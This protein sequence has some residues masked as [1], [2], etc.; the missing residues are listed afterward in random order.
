M[1]A[2]DD[3]AQ[4][5]HLRA[6]LQERCAEADGRAV[7]E[8]LT[9]GHA[10]VLRIE[11]E[12]ARNLRAVEAALHRGALDDVEAL[13]RRRRALLRARGGLR[14]DLA[15]LGA[16]RRANERVRP[17]AGAAG[18]PRDRARRAS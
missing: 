18:R 7:V 9:T 17:D 15:V 5:H 2:A 1:D 12:L 6:R 4:V 16:R 10:V 14:A 11:A 8:L 13:H 3:I